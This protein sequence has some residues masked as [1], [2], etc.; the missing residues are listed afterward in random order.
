MTKYEDE[1]WKDL[2]EDVKAA[3]ESL[4][5]EI[6]AGHDM[7]SSID[8]RPTANPLLLSVARSTHILCN[9]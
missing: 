5:I 9:H 4:W 3:G 8:G 6:Y 2:P 7:C 1:D